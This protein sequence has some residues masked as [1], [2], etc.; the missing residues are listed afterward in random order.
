MIKMSDIVRANAEIS[1]E[2]LKEKFEE[3]REYTYEKTGKRGKA[4]AVRVAIKVAYKQIQDWKDR[5]KK[6][7]NE[8]YQKL[9]K[10]I[11]NTIEGKE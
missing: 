4:E 1:N 7:V 3:L 6:I 9:K 2:D 5:E 11:E 8:D 10:E